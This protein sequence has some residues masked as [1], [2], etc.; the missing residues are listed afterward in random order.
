MC[1][2]ASKESSPVRGIRWPGLAE[3]EAVGLG[4]LVRS[5]RVADMCLAFAGPAVSDPLDWSD[6]RCAYCGLRGHSV[7]RRWAWWVLGASVSTGVCRVSGFGCEARM[8]QWAAQWTA[9]GSERF[10]TVAG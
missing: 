4:E 3:A 6:E 7:L 1:R 10:V 8:R 2:M 9:L 5:I